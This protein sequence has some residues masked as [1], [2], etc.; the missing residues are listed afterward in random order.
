MAAYHEAMLPELVAHVAEA[1]DYSRD[2]EVNAS[3]VDHA[4]FIHSRTA[5]ELW[6]LCTVADVEV[7][8]TS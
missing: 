2:G 6:Q 7:M 3:E 8:R 5:K 4:M 1:I